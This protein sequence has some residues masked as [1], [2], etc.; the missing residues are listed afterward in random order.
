MNSN[1]VI[2]NPKDFEEKKKKIL[3]AGKQNLHVLADFDRTLTKAFVNGRKV[4]G[5]MAELRTGNYMGEEYSR[6]AKELA[7]KYYPIEINPNI[8]MREKMD[9]ME[10]WW[11]LHFKLLIKSGLKKEY[12]DQIVNSGR[13]QFREGVA[14]FLDF[15]DEEKIPLVIMSSGGIASDAISAVLK[16]DK[17]FYK[18]INIISNSYVWDSNGVAIDFKKPVIHVFNKGEFSIKP[19]PIYDELLKRKNVLLLGDSLG[20]LGMIEGFDYDN[21]IKIGFLH[22]KVEESLEGFKEAYDVL[23]LNDGNMDFVNELLGDIK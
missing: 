5:A 1:I 19:L 16:K 14:G 12:I 20:D 2:S 23:V 11:T 3:E 21:L 9:A 8:P 10:E 7:E 13:I 22:D 15:L 6:K 4:S 17:K 18:N